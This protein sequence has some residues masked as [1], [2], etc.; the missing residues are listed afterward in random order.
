MG[1]G[2][3]TPELKKMLIEVAGGLD[4]GV[5]TPLGHLATHLSFRLDLLRERYAIQKK[6]IE[7][8]GGSN[9]AS[10]PGSLSLQVLGIKGVLQHLGKDSVE[11]RE[12]LEKIERRQGSLKEG[13]E[14][15]LLLIQTLKKKVSHVTL[16]VNFSLV[17]NNN[18]SVLSLCA[19]LSS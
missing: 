7:G 18:T 15:C 5:V 8:E 1:G 9:S 17:N 2:L 11:L 10:R 3:T 6:V 12:R 19:V 14:R 4:R 13:A 16:L